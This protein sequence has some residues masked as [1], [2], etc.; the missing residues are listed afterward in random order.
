MAAATERVPI[1]DTA[2]A[3]GV[4]LAELQLMHRG[5]TLTHVDDED[6]E[7]PCGEG[8]YLDDV[9]ERCTA[10]G[11]L[12]E[13]AYDQLT[14]A[15]ASGERSEE[16][17]LAEWALRLRQ[18]EENSIG[19]VLDLHYLQITASSFSLQTDWSLP[20]FEQ[21][22]VAACGGGTIVQRFACDAAL[23][24]HGEQHNHGK[25]ALHA[26]LRRAGYELVLSPG[27]GVTK[28]GQ[29]GQGATDVDVAVCIFD[30]AGAFAQAPRART[31]ALVAGDS[32][33][34]PALVRVL[35][36]HGSAATAAARG[37]GA[38]GAGAG[39]GALRACVVA[40][41]TYMSARYLE[42]IDASCPDVRARA[43]QNR[44]PYPNPGPNPDQV[45]LVP[46]ERLLQ[47]IAPSIL[48]LRGA[49]R[50]RDE[51]TGRAD[52]R[53]VAAAC[54]VCVRVRARARARARAR[55][56][57]LNPNPSPSPSPSPNPSPKLYF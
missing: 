53:A 45:E 22:L 27:K 1:A 9:L 8:D 48:N 52:A 13:R 29:R 19:V 23:D 55:V 51:A 4:A 54:E 43:A 15:L 10:L 20:D 41:R 16:D 35:A 3:L 5:S 57:N 21:A 33:F 36:E 26:R 6:V 24:E 34:K 44:T 40:D 11:L 2:G 7:A 18:W 12:S 49:A 56:S 30:V 17:A 42:W 38:G 31:L 14:D 47:V 28:S 46:L 39:A 37:E 50:P 32:D 25:A